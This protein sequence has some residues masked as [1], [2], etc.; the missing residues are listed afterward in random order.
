MIKVSGLPAQI[1]KSDLD[2][3]FLPYGKIKITRQSITI[4]IGDNQ[5]SALVELD[6]NEELAIELDEKKWRDKYI[7][8]VEIIRGKD[9]D[10]DQPKDGDNSDQAKEEGNSDQ[11]T[12]SSGNKS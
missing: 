6:K 7:L 2:E 4:K 5:S 1:T 11:P 10:L 9:I 12:L 3:L 8:Y